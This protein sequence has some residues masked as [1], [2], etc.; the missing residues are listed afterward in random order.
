MIGRVVFWEVRG[1]VGN[2]I[3]K[4]YIILIFFRNF[5]L[6]DFYIFISVDF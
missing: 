2:F 1:M 3:V 4:N 6:F 5:M